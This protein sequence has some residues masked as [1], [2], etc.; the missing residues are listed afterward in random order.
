MIGCEGV[1]GILAA[2]R[3]AD[4]DVWIGG[5]WGIDALVGEQTRAHGDLDL[6]Y[7]QEQEPRVV[8]SLALEGFTETLDARPEPFVLSTPDG[9]DIDLHTHWPSPRTE[10]PSSSPPIREVRSCTGRVLR[11]RHHRR[12]HRAVSVGPTAGR[13]PSRV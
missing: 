4:V 7:R 12:G 13:L 6:T 5:G 9:R 10:P 11:D 2:L 8:A 1:L 3:R